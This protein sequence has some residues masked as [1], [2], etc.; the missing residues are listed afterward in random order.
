MVLT[1]VRQWLRQRP[2]LAGFAA[3]ALL[4]TAL[5]LATQAPRQ[6]ATDR[7]A[8]ERIVRDYLLAHPEIIPEAINGM[9]SREVT[10]LL[11]SNRTAIETPFAGAY[12]GNKD[13]DV[14]VVEFFD[15][16]CPYCRAAHADVKALLAGDPKVKVV[17]RDFP[18]LSPE[19]D[20]AALA[21]LSAAQQHRYPA[22]YDRMFETDGKLSRERT[23]AAV[24]AAKLDEKRTAADMANPA[25]RTEIKANLELGRALGL[26]GTPSFIIGN[27]ILSGAVGI[28]ALRAAVLTA[29]DAK[30]R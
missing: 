24:R 4:V 8:T 6:K 3:G 29:R 25:L 30:A 16:A 19:S 9:Q 27:K 10:K 18:V 14:V 26:T 7:A 22:F 12:A 17:F 5:T 2:G 21:S 13:G 28:D 1:P 15:Y 11:A 23:I 20:E